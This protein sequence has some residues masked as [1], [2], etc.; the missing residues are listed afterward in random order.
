[1]QERTVNI[2]FSLKEN[3]LLSLKETKNEFMNEVLYLSALH[4]YRKGRLSIGKAAELAGYTK[5]EFIEKLQNEKEFI[6][7][8]S[9]EE[10]DEIFDDADKLKC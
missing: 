7:D 6:F 1:M 4:F 2:C 3:I 5:I 8:Y 9:E 10:M